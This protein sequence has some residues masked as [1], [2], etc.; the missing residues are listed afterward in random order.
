M[1]D[2]KASAYVFPASSGPGHMAPPN[3]RWKALLAEA[4]LENLRLHDLRRTFGSWAAAGNT[5]L[6]LIGRMLGHKSTDA[7]AVY[8]RLHFDPVK[9]AMEAATAAMLA[10]RKQTDEVLASLPPLPPTES[11]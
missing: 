7:T 4:G 2:A 5:S 11:P 6:P 9:E 3:K 8:A 10:N 1:Q